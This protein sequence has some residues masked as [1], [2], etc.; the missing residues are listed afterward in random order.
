MRR[1]FEILIGVALLGAAVHSG[2][3]NLR[4]ARE[5]LHGTG[6]VVEVLTRV[7]VDDG[8]WTLTQTPVV[9]FTPA[10]AAASRRFQSSIWTQVWFAPKT[11]DRVPVVYLADQPEN[12]R[13]ASWQHWLVSVLLAGFGLCCVMG[14]VHWHTNERRRFGWGEH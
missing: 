11:G 13:I 14:W 9:E 4:Y 6:V 5:G 12:V 1:L 3:E 10:G 2:N 7:E 8:D